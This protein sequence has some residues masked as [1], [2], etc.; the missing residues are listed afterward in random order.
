[1]LS[2]R[3]FVAALV[4]LPL[5]AHAAPSAPAWWLGE[6]VEKASPMQITAKR[7]GGRTIKATRTSQVTPT[8]ITLTSSTND[9]QTFHMWVVFPRQKDTDVFLGV[10]GEWFMSDSYGHDD[11]G[12]QASFQFDRATAVRLAKTLK[13]TLNERTKLDAGLQA[14]WTIPARATTDKKAAIPVKVKVKNAG[15]TTIGFVIGGRQRGARDNR[16]SFTVSRNG[17]PVAIK[18]APDFG[19]IMFYKKLGPGE[20]HELTVDLRSWADLATPGMYQIDVKYE[21][22]LTKDGVMPSTAAEQKNLWD[23]SLAGQGGILVQ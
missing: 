11:T 17:K 9:N 6:T 23:V 18:D 16:F 14:T 2:R 12:S 21:G 19:G 20:E 13:L 22:E 15:T 4:A 3:S 5:M 10:D 8:S 1:M 7:F